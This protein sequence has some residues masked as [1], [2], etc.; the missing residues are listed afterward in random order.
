MISLNDA[1][2][3]AKKHPGNKTPKM[4][5]LRSAKT[6]EVLSYGPL[7]VTHL[8]M[9]KGVTVHCGSVREATCCGQEE[10]IRL[11]AECIHK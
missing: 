4:A 5:T 9:N 7:T 3:E 2:V 11:R 10:W 1:A 8:V 6:L